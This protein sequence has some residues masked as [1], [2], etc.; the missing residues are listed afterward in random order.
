VRQWVAKSR[1]RDRVR[2][3]TLGEY[4]DPSALHL[5]SPERFTAVWQA[6]LDAAVPWTDQ[7]SMERNAQRHEAW[8]QC[9]TLAQHPRILDCLTQA[10]ARRGVVGEERA[11]QLLYLAVTSRVLDCPVSCVIKGPSSGGKSYLV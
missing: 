6:A 11:S 8:A 2:F 1:I 7:A 5:A 9:Q 4:K 3:V 10:M